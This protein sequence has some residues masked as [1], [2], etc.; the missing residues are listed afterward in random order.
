MNKVMA[1]TALAAGLM[2]S[3]AA[4]AAPVNLA[5]AL[6]P[7][8]TLTLVRSGGGGGGG[9]LSGGG[10][11]MGGLGGGGRVAGLAA[12]GGDH[13]GSG[14]RFSG[15]DHVAGIGGPVRGPGGHYNGHFDNDHVGRADYGHGHRGYYRNYY[16][17][18]FAFGYDGDYGDYD[19]SYGGDCSWLLHQA[20]ITG[21]R[22]WR[23]RY[24]ACL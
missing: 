5:D 20:N 19:Y 1:M 6:A 14:G 2:V 18:L 10:G 13:V 7:Q 3:T 12:G 16:P 8:A 9:G 15:G 21:S 23:R 22:Y 11:H 24:Q 4:L 17:G